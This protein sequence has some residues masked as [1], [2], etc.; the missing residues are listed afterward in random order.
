[1][2]AGDEVRTIQLAA[3]SAW[4]SCLG[5]IAGDEGVNVCG[6]FGGGL[7]TSLEAAAPPPT[8]TGSCSFSRMALVS[9]ATARGRG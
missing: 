8:L 1:M 4:S 6:G 2:R 3:G 5:W 7:G 9:Q